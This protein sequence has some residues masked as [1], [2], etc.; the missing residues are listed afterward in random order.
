MYGRKRN[1][2]SKKMKNEWILSII[3]PSQG[4]GYV[5]LCRCECACVRIQSA[6]R[7]LGTGNLHSGIIPKHVIVR[8]GPWSSM[9]K[10]THSFL[11]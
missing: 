1:W 10:S 7:S 8:G 9:L 4:L 6:A 11:E 2:K 5:A 3:Y